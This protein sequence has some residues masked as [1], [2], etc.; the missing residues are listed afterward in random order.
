[1]ESTRTLPPYRQHCQG[2]QETAGYTRSVP[3]RLIVLLCVT[4]W[5]GTF[6]VGA[7]PALLPDI[8][9]AASLSD[10]EL[11]AL[12]GMFGFARML[13]DIPVGLFIGRH[14]RWALA[15]GPTLLGLG[16]LCFA[17]GHPVALLFVAR[18]LMGI[19]Q[20]FGM[21]GGLSCILKFGKRERLGRALNA[22]EFSAMIGMLGGVTV[23]SSLPASLPWNRALL[24]AC[25]PQLI[26]IA[27]IP[28]V[29]KSLPP[30]ADEPEPPETRTW[31]GATRPRPLPL[32]V[33][34]AFAAGGTIA[35]AYATIEQ[36]T[37][38]LRASREFGLDR[39]GIA[40]L[41]MIAQVCDIALL[42][43]LGF[44]A[45]RFGPARLLRVV[46]GSL[47][48]ALLLTSFSD[49][50]GAT[51][52]VVCYGIGMAGWMLPLGVLRRETEARDV[53]WRT[54]IYRVCVD[55]GMF[56]GPFASGMLASHAGLLPALVAT[57]LVL[58]AVLIGRRH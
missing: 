27:M 22:F 48:L 30:D 49:L 54:A 53:P 24:L 18:A 21:I 8:A 13:A 28:F 50:T 31:Y 44:L 38:P 33:L 26:G 23:I 40:R 47:A 1:M 29:L 35:I 36:F 39:A 52:G 3:R 10:R 17:Y 58:V 45:D 5:S 7:L 20:A 2:F 11:G 43:P 51:V 56:L 37:V 34:L 14:L 6:S 32:G 42:L 46:M 4:V 15:L 41:L 19:A 12:A 57:A 16:V 55:G 9:R 25:L